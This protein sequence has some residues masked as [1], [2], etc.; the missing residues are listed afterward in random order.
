MPSLTE[1]IDF[2]ISPFEHLVSSEGSLYWLYLLS[3]AAIGVSAYFAA[4]HK[5]DGS[6][7]IR[8]VLAFLFPE[9]V[10]QHPSAKLDFRF[11]VLNTLLFGGLIA[12]MLL[13]SLTVARGTVGALVALFGVPDE[14]LMAGAVAQ[15]GVTVAVVVAADLGF[16]VS[17]Y[18]QHKV[19]VLWEFHKVHHSAEV[20]HP[21]TAFRVHPVDQVLDTVLMGS[22]TGIV[23]GGSAYCFGTSTGLV[24]VVGMNAFVF[25]F[26][27]AG[28]HLRHSHIWLSYGAKL[29]HIFV[30]PAMHQIHYSLAPRHLDKNIG[31]M[32]SIWDWLLGTLYVPKGEEH[33]AF[34]LVAG[35]HRNYTSISRLYVVP[36]LKCGRL[37]LRPFRKNRSGYM[38]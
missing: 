38:D 13:S 33:L 2:A 21:I 34:G 26:N 19:P 30:S 10:Y 32:L 8:N 5:R 22:M 14:P 20:L 11:F 36:L 15:I 6:T 17:H 35:E 7:N 18:L 29:D 3:S 12:P 9:R 25:L 28:A 23:L 27:L 1:L 24:T 37:S 4:R 31:G 16:Y